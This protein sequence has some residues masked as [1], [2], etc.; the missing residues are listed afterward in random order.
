[1]IKDLNF[2]NDA[3]ESAGSNYLSPV[4]PDGSY[5]ARISKA[6]VAQSK[7]G[8]LQIKWFLEVRL[9][10]GDTESLIKFSP[11]I[12]EGMHYLKN[13]LALIGYMPQKIN[14]IYDIL[15]KLTDTLVEIRL[16]KKP[17]S[18]YYTVYFVRRLTA[19]EFFEE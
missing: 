19:S 12:P 3:F 1:M 10:G 15:P 2:L 7:K 5:K 8:N 6:E 13:D 9:P 11:L 18:T 17:S 14:E 16:S 4:I